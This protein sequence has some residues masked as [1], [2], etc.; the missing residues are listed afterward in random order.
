MGPSASGRTSNQRP[1]EQYS[2]VA[3]VIALILLMTLRM[4]FA[5][6]WILVFL[7]G[8]DSPAVSFRSAILTL[9][10]V[11]VA[12]AA[13]LVWSSSLT[14]I[15]W[16]VLG[17]AVAC[18]LTGMFLL[19]S[20]TPGLAVNLGLVFAIL[21]SPSSLSN[22][23]LAAAMPPTNREPADHALPGARNDVLAVRPGSG[24]RAHVPAGS[25]SRV[26]PPRASTACSGSITSSLSATSTPCIPMARVQITRQAQLVAV[27]AAF[28]FQYPVRSRILLF[29]GAALT[30]RTSATT[31]QSAAFRLTG[32]TNRLESTRSDLTPRGID[33]V[34][35]VLHDIISMPM[36]ADPISSKKLIALPSSKVPS[37]PGSAPAASQTIAFALKISLCDTLCYIIP[38]AVGWPGISNVHH[39]RVHHRAR[40]QRG[41]KQRLI[42]RVAGAESGASSSPLAR[43]SFSFPIWTSITS[44]VILDPAVTFFSAWMVG[45]RQFNFVGVQS[46]PDEVELASADHPGGEEGNCGG[47]QDQ[48]SDRVHVGKEEDGRAKGEDEAPD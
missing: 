25:T 38:L 8:R 34:D 7:I 33:R 41:L 44:L 46:H 19:S 27:S 20:T 12:I 22:T 21:M 11:T 42:F 17:I 2:A 15:R 24:C 39:H 48:R 43:P 40:H 23:S 45:G 1:L 13:V 16:R 4:P 37:D 36:E 35:L 31:W 10:V 5:G 18:F 28:G 3:S 6:L 14:T 47:E 30:S 9:L 29:A 26:S 32:S